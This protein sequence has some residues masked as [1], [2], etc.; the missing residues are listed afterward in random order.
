M[1]LSTSNSPEL[2]RE[3]VLDPRAAA[4][5]PIPTGIAITTRDRLKVLSPAAPET[6]GWWRIVTVRFSPVHLRLILRRTSA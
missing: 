4:R 6:E 3:Q 2:T 1:P 5:V